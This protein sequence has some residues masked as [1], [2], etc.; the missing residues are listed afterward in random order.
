MLEY[1]GERV[2]PHLM[3]PTNGMLLEHVARYHFSI[4]YIKGRALDIACGSG[5]GSQMIAKAAKKQLQELVSIDSDPQT[6][7]Y[8]EGA[9]YHP[10][11]TF[12]VEDAVN[13]ELPN[14]L[15][16]FDVIISF[17]TIE[18]ITEEEQ[19]MDNIYNMLKPGGTLVLSTPFGSGRGKTTLEPFHVHQLTNEE[20]QQLFCRYTNKDFFYQKGVLVEP[21][22][23]REGIHYPFGI[24]VCKK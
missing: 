24:A 18:H 19:F 8:A 7:Q 16:Q 5:Y 12:R 2:I 20:F 9:Y 22:P 21:A 4:P 17:E 14:R 13:P 23:G 3:K 6:I 1:T 15:G 11:I 10:L